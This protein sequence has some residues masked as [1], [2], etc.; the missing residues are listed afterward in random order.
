M[1]WIYDWHYRC[2]GRRNYNFKRKLI[3]T[4]YHTIA[5]VEFYQGKLNDVD[6]VLTRSG[7]GKVN[8]AISTTLLIQ[9]FKPEMIINT[10]SAGALMKTYQ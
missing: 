5:H 3:N 4:Q 7:I 6:V 8:A 1:R 10:G 9:Q 2:Y